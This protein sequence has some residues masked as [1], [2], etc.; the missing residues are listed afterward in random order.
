MNYQQPI[1]LEASWKAT[2]TTAHPCDAHIH[3]LHVELFPL[4]EQLPPNISN[5]SWAPTITACLDETHHLPPL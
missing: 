4:G 5:M 3:L 1:V 2:Q